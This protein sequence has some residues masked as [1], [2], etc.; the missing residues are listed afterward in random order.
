MYENMFIIRK[1][2]SDGENNFKQ[3]KYNKWMK[4]RN[5]P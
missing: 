1:M 5:V 2:Y 4:Y 3:N